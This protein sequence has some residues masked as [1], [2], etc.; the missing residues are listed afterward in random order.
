MRLDVPRAPMILVATLALA[1]GAEAQAPGGAFTKTTLDTGGGFNS[2]VIGADGLGLISYAAYHDLSRLKV[3]HCS[4]PAC[5]SATLTTLGDVH[6]GWD[7]SITLGTDGRALISH[8][9]ADLGQ[10]KVTRCADSTCSSATTTTVGIGLLAAGYGTSIAIGGDGRALVTYTQLGAD[11]VLRV[12]HCADADCSTATTAFVDVFGGIAHSIAIGSDGLGLIAYVGGGDSLRVAHCENAA[13]STVTTS[14]LDAAGPSQEGIS[15]VMGADGRGLIAYVGAAGG[16][17]VAHC[18]DVACTTATT[19]AL[20]DGTRPSIGIGPDGLGVIAYR[21]PDGLRRAHCTDVACTSAVI[22][23][24]D[25]YDFGSAVAMA[26]GTDG[27]PLISYDG[28]GFKVAHQAP[29][30]DFNRDGRPDLVWRRDVTGENLVW[31]MNGVERLGAPS[32]DPAA[33]ADPGWRIVG[34]SDFNQDAQPDLLWRHAGSG[35]NAVWLMNG[36]A[37]ASGTF[38]TPLADTGLADRRHG[39]LR[40]RRA[41][42]PPVAPRRLGRERRLVHERDGPRE[43]NVPDPG[44]PA[45]RALAGR[46]TRPISTG[47]AG[48]DILWHHQASGQAVLWYMNGSVLTSGTFTD[49]PALPDTRWRIAAVG[50]YNSDAAPDLVWHNGNSGQAVV[51]FM[52]G[53]TL[54]NG[55]FTNPSIFPDTNW[56]LVGPR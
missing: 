45:G 10:V 26:V 8:V 13:C 46:G 25:T 7:T 2:V 3:A 47:T 34:T 36:V 37:L 43:R 6:T 53:A 19:T 23:G 22:A 44:V 35:E 41:A 12:A 42:G 38:T 54:V 39:G 21:G 33:L 11:G 51:W 31:L 40:P 27:L 30:G 24:V 15:A 5:S 1:G 32:M 49:P 50:D 20:T 14:T 16:I 29:R 48:P 56:K 28:T 52:N 18:N 17:K 9:D 4:D 55:T